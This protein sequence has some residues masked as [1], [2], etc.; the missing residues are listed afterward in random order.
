[1]RF[2]ELLRPARGP[3]GLA[4]VRRGGWLAGLEPG[5]EPPAHPLH[6]L[7]EERERVTEAAGP[8]PLWSGYK[9]VRN[10]PHSTEGTRTPSQVRTAEATGRWYTW[11]AQ[12]RTAPT[13][14]EFGT[15]FGVSGMYWLSGVGDGH[16]YTF[17]PNADWAALARENLAAVSDRFTLTND[18]FETTGPRILAPQSVDI[19]FVDAI[20]TSEFV[21]RQYDVLKPLMKPGGL[22]LFDDISF[23]RDMSAC[24]RRISKGPGLA[25][26]LTLGRRVGMVELA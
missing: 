12:Q 9:G 15:A 19:A 22:I 25:G 24:W 21:Q 14:V 17:E 16:L 4:F 11:L 5:F 20:H 13:I 18:I 7:I 1:M 10:Y 3:A 2:F 23:S 8:R 6:R 26:S